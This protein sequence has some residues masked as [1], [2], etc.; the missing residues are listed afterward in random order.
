MPVI[1]EIAARQPI[2]AEWRRML[3]AMPEL[4]FE[5][6]KTAAFV[7]DRL[8]AMGIEVHT[9]MANTGV[10]GVIEGRPG[11]RRI[12]LRA[13][14]D[15]LPM[16]ELGTPAWRS[17]TP[18]R[19]HGCG[20][21]GHT[22]MLLAA[23]EYL[24]RTRAFDGTVVL[25]F[26]PA[27]EGLG[28]GRVMVEEGLFERFPCDEIYALHN[29][30]LLPVGQAAVRAG[31][32]LASFD[33]FDVVITGRG[34]HAAM[35]HKTIDPAVVMSQTVLALQALISRETDPMESAVLSVTEMHIGTTHNVIASEGRIAGTVRALNE[36]AR[37][38]IE[39]GFH[40]VVTHVAE[41]Y[42]ASARIEYVREFPVL[43][44]DAEAAEHAA[45]AIT[46]VLGPTGLAKS[47]PPLMA[48][49]DFAFM[50]QKRPGAYIL[51]GQGKGP[52]SPMVHHPE[53]DFNDAII[54]TGAS[55][56]VALVQR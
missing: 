34:G 17:R 28:G 43:V 6:E 26:Q 54:A 15:A 49:E 55:L 35:P 29:M 7:V 30:P 45:R 27:E 25:I 5:E 22:V 23:A 51:V 12:G 1:A 13:D 40:R 11:N 41:A 42:G 52:D 16:D 48:A 4:G 56:F 14:M 3:H 18:G 10:V 9:G 20:H 38:R 24:A 36:A 47:F 21:D 31:A 39:A 50:L 19:F 33:R 32:A 44:N 53:Y 37:A 8:K 46:D 2:L